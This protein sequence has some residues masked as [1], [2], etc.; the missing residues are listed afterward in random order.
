MKL[1]PLACEN[2]HVKS[3]GAAS[4]SVMSRNTPHVFTSCMPKPLRIA[5]MSSASTN[6]TNAAAQTKTRYR[7]TDD[8]REMSFGVTN[9]A[10]NA[11]NIKTNA[12]TFAVN[13]T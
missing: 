11:S 13:C 12:A 8:S 7:N 4:S 9:C 10:P 1:S 5:M 2:V 3:C 6:K